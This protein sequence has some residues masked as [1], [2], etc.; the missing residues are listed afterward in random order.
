M[1]VE[2][3]DVC[4]NLLEWAGTGQ[5]PNVPVRPGSACF[6][7]YTLYRGKYLDSGTTLRCV[8]S[9][10]ENYVAVGVSS[11]LCSCF[12]DRSGSICHENNEHTDV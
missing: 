11:E 7:V 4:L 10:I 5:L 9:R 2:R 6:C 3:C 1:A 12:G 8:R